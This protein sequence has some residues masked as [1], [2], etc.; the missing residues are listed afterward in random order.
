MFADHIRIR[1]LPQVPEH[2]LMLSNQS[3]VEEVKAQ[4]GAER[5]GEREIEEQAQR[6][7]RVGG[8]PYKGQQELPPAPA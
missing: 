5:S 7:L 2:L 8:P 1:I 3:L 6:D 4:V